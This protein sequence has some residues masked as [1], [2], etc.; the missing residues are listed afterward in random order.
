MHYVHVAESHAREWP[1]AVHDAAC[2]EI[3]PDK[4]II[5]VVAKPWQKVRPSTPKRSSPQAYERAQ[6]DSNLRHPA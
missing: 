3:D 1:D 2:T 4:R 6:Q 5:A